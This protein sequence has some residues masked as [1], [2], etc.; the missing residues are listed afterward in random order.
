MKSLNYFIR[1]SFIIFICLLFVSSCAEEEKT[2]EIDFFENDAIPLKRKIQRVLETS[3]LINLGFKEEHC[4][5]LQAYYSNRNYKAQWIN[6]SVLNPAGMELKETLNRSL[7]F[8]IP[9]N[10]L[11]MSELSKNNWVEQEVLLTAKTALIL[12]D[13]NKGFLNFEEKKYKGEYFVTTEYMDSI[14][15]LNKKLRFAEILLVQGVKDSN[16]QFMSNKLYEFC[17][18][19][20]MDK[21]VFEIESIRTDSLLAE[22]KTKKALVSKGYLQ[23]EDVDST[24]FTEALM[25]FQKHNGLKQDAVIGKHTSHALNESTYSKVLRAA[26]NMDRLRKDEKY[27]DRCIRINIPEYKL[28]FYVKDSLKRIHNIVVGTPLN[29][30]PQLQSKIRSIVVYPYWTVPYSIS[31]KEIL[32]AVK[33]NTGYLAKNNYK[34]FRNDAEVNPYSVNWKKIKENSFPYK[35]RQEPGPKNSLGIIKFEFHNTYS[36]YVHDTPAKSLFRTDIRAYSHGCMR[37]ENPV[38]LG[39]T[40]LDYDSVG[41]KRNDLTADSLD[42]LLMRAENYVIK[43]KNPVPIFVEYATVYADR[44]VIIFYPDI[45]KREE[46]YLKIMKD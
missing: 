7:W 15:K 28:R 16:Y 25:L 32:P 44:D 27:P 11:K 13:L 21:S 38:D 42:T 26:L 35:V 10:R 43:L 41:R 29:Q 31:S 23:K 4:L 34:I 22:G 20:P 40:I 18:S 17:S 9:D 12:H 45:Y 36:V 37:C 2:I 8:G 14:I 39:R 46:E 30:T 5:W 3:Y 6:D 24:T 1:Y 33:R 19:Y